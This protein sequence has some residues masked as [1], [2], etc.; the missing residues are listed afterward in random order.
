MKALSQTSIRLITCACLSAALLIV[1]ADVDA[2]T[3]SQMGQDA[4][5]VFQQADTELN[6]VYQRILADYASA[7]QFTQKLRDA[8]R[9]WR[10]FRDAHLESLYP[11]PDKQAAYG[12]AYQMC[13]CSVLAGLTKQ[14]VEELKQWLNGVPEGEVCAGSIRR[15]APQD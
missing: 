15:A 2:E 9:A 3:Q 4:C 14:R 10:A 1:R 5:A 12:S 6:V 13:R 11:E 8:Q 7:P